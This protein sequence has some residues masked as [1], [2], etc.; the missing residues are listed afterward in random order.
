VLSL[1]CYG[2]RRGI[3]RKCLALYL[4]KVN[5][6]GERL[7]RPSALLS[8]DTGQLPCNHRNG[9]SRKITAHRMTCTEC[10]NKRHCA[11]FEPYELASSGKGASWK[12]FGS[13]VE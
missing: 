9:A 7:A 10:S 12:N 2:Q 1:A 4:T 11:S 13:T 5:V 3:M 8:I 6:F